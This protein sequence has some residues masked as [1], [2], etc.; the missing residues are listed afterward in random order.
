MNEFMRHQTGVTSVVSTLTTLEALTFVVAAL[1]HVGLT[2]PLGFA[3]LSEPQIIPAAIVE[4]LCGTFLAAAAYAAF[5]Q[6]A[7][8][9]QL[10]LAAHAF[11][12]AGVALGTVALAVGAGPR[13]V[14]NDIIYH[15]VM[16][17]TLGMGMFLLQW[18]SARG[19][20]TSCKGHTNTSP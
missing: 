7:A 15:G 16:V 11:A 8:A 9:W 3:Q 6:R 4:G 18:P 13:T 17:F 5:T 10:T 20:L 14:G 19:P 2:I 1:L 12:L